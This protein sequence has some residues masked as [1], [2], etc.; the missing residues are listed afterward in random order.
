[1]PLLHAYVKE[2]CHR[3]IMMSASLVQHHGNCIMSYS[4]FYSHGKFHHCI[5]P[6]L[7]SYISRLH[8]YHGHC[9][10]ASRIIPFNIINSLSKNVFEQKLTL[11]SFLSRFTTRLRNWFFH[12]L[13]HIFSAKSY[14]MLVLEWSTGPFQPTLVVIVSAYIIHI[15]LLQ[16]LKPW[17][18]LV[19]KNNW[20]VHTVARLISTTHRPY[21]VFGSPLCYPSFHNA[22]PY[23]ISLYYSRN[24]S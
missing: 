4:P 21:V 12:N 24:S 2:H 6:T 22:R 18:F 13:D 10:Y 11:I 3:C 16:K 5:A 20:L 7:Q 17:S 19:W 9:A 15:L 14:Y 23:I 1:M 8:H